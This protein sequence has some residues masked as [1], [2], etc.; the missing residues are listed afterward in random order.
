M[1]VQP[2]DA[3]DLRRPAGLPG[4]VPV[5]LVVAL[6]LGVAKQLYGLGVQLFP[7]PGPGNGGG[8]YIPLSLRMAQ[9]ALWP[10]YTDVG[11]M[12]LLPAVGMLWFT[13]SR[14]SWTPTPGRR[15][16]IAAAALLGF[17]AALAVLRA[18]GVLL[19]WAGTDD[20]SRAN[21]GYVTGS[22]ALVVFNS[23]LLGQLWFAAVG[24]VLTWCL[25]VAEAESGRVQRSPAL[26]PEPAPAEPATA[27]VEDPS[28]TGAGVDPPLDWRVD[29]RVEG[30]EAT[31]RRPRG[32]GTRIPA[33][34]D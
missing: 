16:R 15:T 22:G 5:V 6:A 8:Q 18:V 27:R 26:V 33:E 3:A 2:D 17:C 29:W 11:P 7:P 24:G 31:Y 10:D 34:A 21:I 28:D 9:W 32:E 4:W 12:V 19:W 1:A 13:V 23:G 30:A 25:V 14:S 20:V